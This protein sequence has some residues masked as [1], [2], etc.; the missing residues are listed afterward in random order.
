MRRALSA[1]A[2]AACALAL[3]AAPVPAQAPAQAAPRP[4]A[5]LRIGLMPAV[6]SIPLIVADHLSYFERAGVP[7]ELV[8]FQDQ[9]TRETALQTGRIDGSISDLIN[10]VSARASGFDVRV[11]SGTD[12]VFALLGA[13]GGRLRSLEDWKARSRVRTGL[14]ESSIVTFLTEKMLRGAGV[15]PRT[16]DLVT[17]LQVPTRMELLLSGR[18][19]AACLPEPMA[20]VAVRRGA[21]RIADTTS[22]PT[23]PGVLLFTG[24]AVRERGREIATLLEAYDLA[25]AELNRNGNAWRPLVVAKGGFPEEARDAFVLPRFQPS[26]PPTLEDVAEVEN[27]MKAHGL[28]RDTVAYGDLVARVR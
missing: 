15:D 17:T 23:T 5:S 13:P 8:M 19:D 11:V 7:V 28:L 14:V 18:I 26:M 24:R 27:W 12:G 10:A 22:L 2:A 4:G 6:N 21:I 20:A 9:L 3:A 1:A 16:I 25:V